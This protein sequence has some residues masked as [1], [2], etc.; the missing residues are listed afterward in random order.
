MLGRGAEVGWP[1]W[2]PDGRT[3]LLD[4]TTKD[5]RGVMFTIGVDQ[6]SGQVTSD[7]A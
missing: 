3:L 5:G 7:I 6:D 2:A 4:G 1:R